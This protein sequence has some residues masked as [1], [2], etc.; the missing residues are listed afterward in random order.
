MQ[1]AQAAFPAYLRGIET[2]PALPG[3][4]VRSRFQPTYEGLKP[5]SLERGFY[6]KEFPAYLRGIETCSI[7]P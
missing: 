2:R 1:N 7:Y 3:E 4:S 6:G 5:F